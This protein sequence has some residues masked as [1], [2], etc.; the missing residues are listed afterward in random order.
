MQKMEWVE[1]EFVSSDHKEWWT[2]YAVGC[3][4]CECH[5]PLCSTEE[6]AISYWNNAWKHRKED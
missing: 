3:T 4:N 5:G 6:L 2:T 1:G